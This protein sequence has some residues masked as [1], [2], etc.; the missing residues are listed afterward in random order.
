MQTNNI[1][2]FYACV[3]RMQK[4]ILL[5]GTLSGGNICWVKWCCASNVEKLNNVA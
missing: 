4:H 1:V 5:N 2:L 3:Q